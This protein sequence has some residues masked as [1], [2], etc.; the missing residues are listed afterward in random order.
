MAK[1][2]IQAPD[3]GI[4]KITGVS[5]L[6]QETG[7]HD[8]AREYSRYDHWVCDGLYMY[9]VKHQDKQLEKIELPENM[10]GL[11]IADGP[12][13]FVFGQKAEKLKARFWIK[14]QLRLA[15]QNQIWIEAYP[16][17]QA[18]AANYKRVDLIL[19]AK[20]MYPLAI[21]THVPDP[22]SA[23]REVYQFDKHSV[24]GF[25]CW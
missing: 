23:Q 16:K 17:T 18:D 10:R 15:I 24:N 5:I 22:K 2:I 8:A 3:R 1:S 4:F 13:P 21:Q 12:L 20:N 19:D 11:Q 6:N 25:L 14:S 7:K 9:Q